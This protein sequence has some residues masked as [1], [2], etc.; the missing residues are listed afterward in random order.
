MSTDLR[1]RD[2]LRELFERNPKLQSLLLETPELSWRY[3]HI[4]RS[5][6]QPAKK[7][8]PMFAWSTERDAKGKFRSWVWHPKKDGW[9]LKGLRSHARRKDAKA[10]A[11]RM[12]DAFAEKASQ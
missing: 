8:F 5:L 1:L 2:E 10:R 11:L 9:T 6:E 3:F 4:G 7:G 12:R